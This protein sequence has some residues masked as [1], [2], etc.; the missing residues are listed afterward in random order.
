MTELTEAKR[1]KMIDKVRAMLKRTTENGCTEAEALQAAKIAG[2]LMD[3]YNLDMSVGEAKEEICVIR[4][5]PETAARYHEVFNV[6]G[7]LAAYTQVRIWGW[8]RP[9]MIHGK[10]VRI[11]EYRFFGFETDVE[12][13]MALFTSIKN[14]INREFELFMKQRTAMGDRTSASTYRR[15]FKMSMAA[16]ISDRLEELTDT[17]KIEAAKKD[18]E[19]E[20]AVKAGASA[21]SQ[22]GG[23][24]LVLVKNTTVEDQFKAQGI[25]KNLKSLYMTSSVNDGYER[26]VAQSAGHA[27]GGR[28]E[29]NE[30]LA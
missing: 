6:C 23:T 10:Q 28:F 19:N 14:A 24:A 26:R 4:H 15:N 29:I 30:K 1:K 8:W 12:V 9:K 2:E 25:A 27:A 18:A 22:T 5:I 17:R 11:Y 3:K 13:A 21:D 7:A 20:A 16:R